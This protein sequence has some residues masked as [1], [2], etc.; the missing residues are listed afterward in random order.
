MRV[1]FISRLLSAFQVEVGEELNRRPDIEY[2]IAFTMR[3]REGRGQPHWTSFGY[4]PERY[5][6]MPEGG[7]PTRWLVDQIREYKPDVLIS[8]QVV[9]ELYDAVI[10]TADDVPYA[11]GFWME[12]PDFQ[13]P[14]AYL[15]AAR[16]VARLRLS[17]A[18]FIFAIGERAEH[19]FAACAP[20]A[21]MYLIPY[22]ADLSYCFAATPEEKQSERMRFLFS[23]QLLAR[24][25]IHVISESLVRLW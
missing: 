7:D 5:P 16:Q 11:L 9:H 1:L 25:N 12:P 15:M 6:V 23:G 21:D 8:G 24:H 22:G 10:A 4:D 2:R 14:A 19:F 3:K 20:H 13:R 17:L 18:D